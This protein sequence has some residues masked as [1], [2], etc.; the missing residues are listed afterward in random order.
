M[1][2][3]AYGGTS[4]LQCLIILGRLSLI[5][6]TAKPTKP[7]ENLFRYQP[8]EVTRCREIWSLIWILTLRTIFLCPLEWARPGQAGPPFHAAVGRPWS[9]LEQGFYRNLL[10]L[11]NEA[12]IIKNFKTIFKGLVTTLTENKLWELILFFHHVGSFGRVFFYRDT[13]TA[14]SHQPLANNQTDTYY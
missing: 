8:A 6:S 11:S 12:W 4:A 5:L 9:R 3:E 10:V 13:W 2:Q 14:L 1:K 7:H